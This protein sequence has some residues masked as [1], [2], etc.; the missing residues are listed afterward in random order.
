MVA[1]AGF[2][3]LLARGSAVSVAE[4]AAAARSSSLA[5]L[6]TSHSRARQWAR[7]H[8]VEARILTLPEAVDL[9]RD[10]WRPLLPVDVV[11]V[12]F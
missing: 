10:N 8:A 5:N 2:R 12:K 3:V 4:L 9:E 11:G 6:C 7:A 1:G